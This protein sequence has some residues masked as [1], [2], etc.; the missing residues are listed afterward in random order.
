MNLNRRHLTGI[1]FNFDLDLIDIYVHFSVMFGLK[2]SVWMQCMESDLINGFW[3]F[4]SVACCKGSFSERNHLQSCM[5]S[6]I[7]TNMILFPTRVVGL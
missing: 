5:V 1:V 4:F 2:M 3:N 7:P 6:L